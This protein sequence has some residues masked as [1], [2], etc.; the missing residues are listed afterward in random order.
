MIV[1]PFVAASDLTTT[2][3]SGTQQRS[4]FNPERH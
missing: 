2:S 3:T 4:F 1:Y